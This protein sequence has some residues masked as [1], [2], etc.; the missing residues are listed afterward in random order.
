[1]PVS[2]GQAALPV[3]AGRVP[4]WEALQLL[5]QLRRVWTES[6]RKHELVS[7][8]RLAVGCSCASNGLRIPPEMFYGVNLGLSYARTAVGLGDPRGSLPTQDI[9]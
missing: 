6:R 3:R 8:P 1:M 9:L 4:A 5:H 2:W 7:A